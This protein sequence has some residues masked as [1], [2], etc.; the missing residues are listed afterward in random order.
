MEYH[1][2]IAVNVDDGMEVCEGREK[3]SSA[4][5]L[6]HDHAQDAHSTT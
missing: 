1:S 5:V 3:S 6:T 2:L 4:L